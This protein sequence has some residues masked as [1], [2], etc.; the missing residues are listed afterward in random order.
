MNMLKYI[1]LTGLMFSLYAS[2]NAQ[3]W[4]S[5][6]STEQVNDLVD[7]GEELILASNVGV[8]VMNK[9]TLEKTIINSFNSNL[10]YDH[11]Q[12]ITMAPDGN[13]F[14]GIYD[15][16]VARF[17]GSDFVDIEV[18]VGISNPNTAKLYDIEVSDDGD[19]WVATSEGIF[20]KQGAN[21]I[22][23]AEEELGD[24]FFNVWDIEINNL[25]EV[26]AGAQNGV[27]KFE[28]GSW[29]NITSGTSLQPYQG[30]ELFF[31]E[32]GDLF[33]A[34]DLD[35]IARYDGAYWN[36]YAMPISTL[37]EVR[38]TEDTE[39]FVYVNNT[40]N[41][42]LRLEG[43][44]WN[45]YTNEQTALFD[46]QISYYYVDSQN[47]HWLNHNIYLSS[48][49]NGDIQSTSISSTSIEYNRI[50]DIEKGP[51]GNMY[52]VMKT[53]TSSAAVYS[54]D[55]GWDYFSLPDDWV[56][57]L[58]PNILYLAADDVWI[59]SSNG[60]YHYDGLEWSINEELGAL[61]PIISDSQGKLYVK[62]FNQIFIVED[63]L[64][65]EYNESN[66]ELN[67]LDVVSAIGV[68]AADN[69]W[70][71]SKLWNGGGVIQKVS[72]DGEWTTYSS[73]DHPLIDKPEG[74]FYFDSAGNTWVPSSQAGV[75]KFD[76]QSFTNPIIEN[77]NNLESYKAYSIDSDAEGRM[78]FSHQ[79]GVTTLLDGVW[80]ELLV[81]GLPTNNSTYRSSIKF[82][83]DGTL[84]W[85]SEVY[86]L[87]SY[88]SEPITST[89]SIDEPFS[90]F[91]I[92]PNP[93]ENE[94]FINFVVQQK[95]NVSI[96]V[97]NN[98]GQ[99]VSNLDLG[100]F[101]KGTY[102]Q[103][104]DFSAYPK[105]IYSLQLKVSDQSSTKK[106]VIR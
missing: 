53:S 47:V 15:V 6:Q 26:Y 85:G 33:V 36:F 21:W 82:D 58:Y 13:T 74:D 105:G 86:G 83:D 48:N 23:Y 54:Q 55:G 78:Y 64:I 101:N 73:E 89:G 71:G 93:T 106:I 12:A 19:L 94:A 65:S 43:D 50:S 98:L 7:N 61:G 77:Q 96:C 63:G 92:F 90:N 42:V 46:G 41:S 20:R 91:S 35:S 39:G 95:S 9:T 37:Q 84:W 30:A 72:T 38:F 5:Y 3:E 52:F 4:T 34:G 102:Q 104:I 14:I 17:D 44:T 51:N 100:S 18:P 97:F 8:V 76:G 69:L 68:D 99:V 24:T 70:I 1:L 49:D 32:N 57:S 81:D 25:G 62:S 75:I 10:Y 79:F 88:T 28:N 31:S 59:S 87:F 22:K 40:I 80:G 60:L 66:S 11:I 45:P 67:S 56:A 2:S 27:H 29:S 103:S 16:T